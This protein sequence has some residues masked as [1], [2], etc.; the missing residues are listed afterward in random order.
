MHSLLFLSL[1]TVATCQWTER[2]LFFYQASNHAWHVNEGDDVLV[3]SNSASFPLQHGFALANYSRV[4]F[5]AIL[6]SYS[7]LSSTDT[8]AMKTHALSEDSSYNDCPLFGKKVMVTV[9]RV[10]H[11]QNKE[12]CVSVET[13]QRYFKYLDSHLRLQSGNRIRFDMDASIISNVCCPCSEEECYGP[14]QYQNF[15]SVVMKNCRAL[16]PRLNNSPMTRIFLNDGF[17]GF[18]GLAS[19]GYIDAFTNYG[20]YW[21]I[22]NVNNDPDAFWKWEYNLS[23]LV[24]E[25]GHT[26]GFGHA[27]YTEGSPTSF[28]T[29][30]SKPDNYGDGGSVMGSGNSWDTIPGPSH[31]YYRLSKKKVEPFYF[32]TLS[33]AT[34]TRIRLFAWDHAYSRPFL[35]IEQSRFKESDVIDGI[36]AGENALTVEVPFNRGNMCSTISEDVSYGSFFIEYRSRYGNQMGAGNHGVRLIQGRVEKRGIDE[37][38]SLILPAGVDGLFTWGDNTIPAGVLWTPNTADLGTIGIRVTRVHTVSERITEEQLDDPVQPLEKQSYVELEVTYQPGVKRI[39]PLH[40]SPLPS[41]QFSPNVACAMKEDVSGYVCSVVGVPRF[42][43]YMNAFAHRGHP[44]VFK[45]DGSWIDSA[46]ASVVSVPGRERNSWVHFFGDY[47]RGKCTVDVEVA[48]SN[49]RAISWTNTKLYRKRVGEGDDSF[50]LVGEGSVVVVGNLEYAA[51][52]EVVL[53]DLCGSSEEVS[54]SANSD[55]F[56]MVLPEKK[57]PGWYEGLVVEKREGRI[58]T[59][60]QVTQLVASLN[61][62]RVAVQLIDSNYVSVHSAGIPSTKTSFPSMLY[63]QRL[64]ANQRFPLMFQD[65]TFGDSLLFDF[66]GTFPSN[67]VMFMETDNGEVQLSLRRLGREKSISLKLPY[68]QLIALGSVDGQ[69]HFVW[70]SQRVTLLSVRAVLASKVGKGI[71]TQSSGV[72]YYNLGE[73]R[74]KGEIGGFSQFEAKQYRAKYKGRWYDVNTESVEGVVVKVRDEGGSSGVWTWVWVVCGVVVAVVVFCCCSCL[75][76]QRRSAKSS[77]PRTVPKKKHTSGAPMPPVVKSSKPASSG[78]NPFDVPSVDFS[79]KSTPP[80][81]ALPKPVVS[82][83]AAKPLPPKPLPPK[84]T[85]ARP[86]PPKPTV[87]KPPTPE[88]KPLPPT[89]ETK[90]LPPKPTVVKPPPSSLSSHP[91]RRSPPKPPVNSK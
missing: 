15:M 13:V 49:G 68:S 21:A 30:F 76:R 57:L 69:I 50:A 47:T 75:C 78:G 64:P 55:G 82:E 59:S 5:T 27:A 14:D 80:V 73:Y 2:K 4:D 32:K 56:A 39:P 20:N 37:S 79:K 18:A 67:C 65:W 51:G 40:P 58:V 1:V 22:N 23:V 34:T 7:F 8:V 52:D 54:V 72:D 3:V 19:L 42:W 45:S 24:H 74:Y 12:G 44:R 81:P 48:A 63:E 91:P 88:T 71:E 43:F 9:Y 86:L 83:S 25:F 33:E 6:S 87:V 11:R 53:M 46:S 26:M 31:Y 17:G 38:R 70:F 16:D 66:E 85:D 41:Y 10:Q 35:G 61:E 77:L 36:P 28:I 29:D 90:P 62:D 60:L 89:P 84:P